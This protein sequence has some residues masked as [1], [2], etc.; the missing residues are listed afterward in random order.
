MG[1]PE[2]IA[3]SAVYV[4]IALGVLLVWQLIENIGKLRCASKLGFSTGW[5][6]FLPVLHEGLTGAM[7]EKC[8]RIRKPASKPKKWSVFYPL[9]E[10]LSWV[11]GFA[12]IVCI[13]IW[14]ATMFT[15]SNR[16]VRNLLS[17]IFGQTE[18]E[19]MANAKGALWITVIITVVAV[20]L[21]LLEIILSL[22][23]TYKIYAAFSPKRH[24]LWFVLTFFFPIVEAFVLLV[25][26]FSKKID[27]LPKSEPEPQQEPQQELPEEPQE[28]PA[29]PEEAQ[30]EPAPELTEEPVPEIKD[31]ET[32]LEAN[33]DD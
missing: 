6:A 20:N 33:K 31:D 2:I 17:F 12:V 30:Q 22:L 16:F 7:A 3:G 32:V 10:V 29:L 15:S 24:G 23:V 13:L 11:S 5:M 21:I 9:V 1:V 25:F 27:P 28:T 14:A 18:N 19:F 4:L 8:D 26:G